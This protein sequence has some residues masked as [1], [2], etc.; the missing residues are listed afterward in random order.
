MSVARLIG[1]A[2]PQRGMGEGAFAP[3]DGVREIIDPPSGELRSRN[4]ISRSNARSSGKYPSWKMHRMMHW[5]SIYER[6]AFCLLDGTSAV[7]AYC[8]QPLTIRYVLRGETHLHYPDIL[9][10]WADGT[11]SLWEIKPKRQAQQE[12]VAERTRLLQAS[13]P[14]HGF[15]YHMMTAEALAQE[16]RWSN[17]QRLLE[18]GRHPVT[19]LER[20]AIRQRLLGEPGISWAAASSGA[21][22]PRGRAVLCRLTL[23]GMLQFDVERKLDHTSVFRL[24]VKA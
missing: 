5:Q 7:R 22:G 23:E 13:L 3:G 19:A 4:I 18:F 2:A 12:E 14:D 8:E 10:H 21:L 9:V 15:D 6:N 24:A 17:V 11:A 20:E 1:R 16:P